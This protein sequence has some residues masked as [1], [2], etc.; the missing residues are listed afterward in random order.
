MTDDTRHVSKR[1]HLWDTWHLRGFIILSLLLQTFLVILAPLRKRTS[2][3]WII[4]PLWL[5]YLLADWVAN[6]A[7]GLITK[8]QG[9][10]TGLLAGKT[11]HDT[12]AAEK[13]LLAFWAP[14]L[15]LHLGGPD[16]ITAF[17][18]EDNEFWLRHLLDVD[19]GKNYIGLK[20]VNHWIN[21]VTEIE[22]I[23]DPGRD[24]NMD[25]TTDLTEIEV[26]QKAYDLFKMFKG[27][28]V[29]LIFT[30][31]TRNK[32]RNFFLNQTAKNAFEV[33]EVELNLFYEALFTKVPVVYGYFGIVTRIISI[34]MAGTSIL[35]F[36]VGDKWK[37]NTNIDANI[38]YGLLC[39]ALAL[40]VI[41]VVV[42]LEDGWSTLLPHTL[43]GD[44][45]QR[46]LLWHIAT[47]LCYSEELSENLVKSKRHV[48]TYTD[49]RE[50]AKL[51]SDY[52]MYILIMKPSM[53]TTVTSITQIQF[54]DLCANAKSNFKNEKAHEV[55]VVRKPPQGS[56]DSEVDWKHMNACMK[57]F[58]QN[59]TRL[60]NM[61]GDVTKSLLVYNIALFINLSR[62]IN[63]IINLSR[64][65]EK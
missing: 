50:I 5:S 38:T 60:Q 46:I 47:D 25:I 37:F 28:S 49:Y 10:P 16:T 3:N 30:R 51:L 56:R 8:G 2:S 32:S 63:S 34:M 27:L 52:M 54:W 21:E 42:R 36:N 53:M 23:Q 19:P 61:K 33:V 62:W 44:F 39:G 20:E 24:A 14:F 1:E 55:N 9:N 59:E 4:I 65:K 15:L 12:I 35:I 26:I 31:E 18:L 13:D 6:F 7:I 57:I 29:D 64:I 45:G 11:D 43:D 22:I 41:A 58:S 48:N 40:D 17:A